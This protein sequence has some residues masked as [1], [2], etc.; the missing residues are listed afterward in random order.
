MHEIIYKRFFI[1]L[2]EKKS[3]HPKESGTTVIVIAPPNVR[4]IADIE[5]TIK[6]PN[7]HSVKPVENEF[8]KQYSKKGKITVAKIAFP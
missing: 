3:I 5:I 8:N 6:N 4:D 1:F 2:L 7:L